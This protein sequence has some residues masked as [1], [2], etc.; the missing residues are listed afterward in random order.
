MKD[1]KKGKYED[2][3]V[4]IMGWNSLRDITLSNLKVASEG[5]QI[6]IC[7]P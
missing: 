2:G 4:M 5:E 7:N 1:D 6:N 3:E